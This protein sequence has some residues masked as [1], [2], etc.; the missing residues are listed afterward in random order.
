[1]LLRLLKASILFVLTIFMSTFVGVVFLYFGWNHGLVPA[2]HGVDS[3]SFVTAFWLSLCLS[4]IACFF[5]TSVTA[6]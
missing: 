6:G 3:I 2:M 5:K 4:T 1:M